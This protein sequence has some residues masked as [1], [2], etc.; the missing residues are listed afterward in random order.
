MLLV[1]L[2]GG[3]L[4]AVQ[5]RQVCSAAEVVLGQG[6]E[7]TFS[8]DTDGLT[9]GMVLFGKR[10]SSGFE[11]VSV[12]ALGKD[13][14]SYTAWFSVEEKCFPSS[15][16]WYRQL[17]SAHSR[18]EKAVTEFVY[19]VGSCKQTCERDGAALGLQ[20]LSVVVH[21]ASRWARNLPNKRHCVPVE[22]A[23]TPQSLKLNT[24]DKPDP[25]SGAVTGIPPALLA[26]AAVAALMKLCAP[27]W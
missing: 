1:C 24:C 5:G 4:P 6:Q 25:S 27:R 2:L 21:G 16:E 26:A 8:Q 19:Q 10:E 17:V 20:W 22:L 14:I 7:H 13:G 12:N 11:G 9:A 3:V 15:D 18:P 23:D